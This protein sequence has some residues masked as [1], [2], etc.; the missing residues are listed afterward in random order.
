MVQRYTYIPR[1]N[2]PAIPA[3]DDSAAAPVFT[4]G[5]T[6]PTYARLMVAFVGKIQ[7]YP[8][9]HGRLALTTVQSGVLEHRVG[10]KLGRKMA[11]TPA[12]VQQRTATNV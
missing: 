9:Q 1:P 3:Q 8:I 12:N 4:V 10:R 6:G 11:I 5:M 7:L 2:R